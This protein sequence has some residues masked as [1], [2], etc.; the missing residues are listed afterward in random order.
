MILAAG[1]QLQRVGQNPTGET[2]PYS[3]TTTLRK[4][5]FTRIIYSLFVKV[6]KKVGVKRAMVENELLQRE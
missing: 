5:R 3:A 2:T 6:K 4:S 1:G